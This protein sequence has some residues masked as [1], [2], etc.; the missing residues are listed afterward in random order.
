L[1]N[2]T[3]VKKLTSFFVE[4]DEQK[5]RTPFPSVR[6][7]TPDEIINAQN[8]NNYEKIV[9]SEINKER[10]EEITNELETSLKF[11]EIEKE[12]ES[13]IDIKK[14]IKLV[15]L[16]GPP[17]SGK[18]TFALQSAIEIIPK[19]TYYI[20]TSHYTAL[21]KRIKQMIFDERWKD[22]NDIKQYFFPIQI[23]SLDELEIQLEKIKR[24]DAHEIGL[25]IID[26]FTDYVRGEIY[27]EENRVKLRQIL[28]TIYL[29]CDEKNCKSLL[30]N[31]FSFVDS[32]PAED[33][34]ES[35]C[36]MTLR[37]EKDGINSQLVLNDEEFYPYFIDNS[38]VRNL[39]I[40]IYF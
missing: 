22:Q 36:D 15:H 23:Q 38:G 2:N 1:G 32:A 39:H 31:G 5:I 17:S 10:E 4:K 7:L 6:Y 34:V 8:S 13:F 35:F 20:I 3:E 40:N 30:L 28:E 9:E 26:H 37:L 16:F 11:S 14:G 12:N 33:L 19:N 21:I 29:I 25:I 24:V 18:T 27:K